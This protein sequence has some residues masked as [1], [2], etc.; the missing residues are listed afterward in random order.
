MKINSNEIPKINFRKEIN[1]LNGFEIKEI[2]DIY[3]KSYN[4]N[5][6]IYSFHKQQFNLIIFITKDNVKHFVD[7]ESYNLNSGDVLFITNNSVHAFDK[8]NSIQGQVILFTDEFLLNGVT[9]QEVKYINN[10]RRRVFKYPV[11]KK[12]LDNE[13]ILNLL[14]ILKEEYVNNKVTEELFY[15]NIL[16]SLII[17]LD[18]NIREKKENSFNSNWYSVMGLLDSSIENN[19]YRLRDSGSLAEGLGYGYKQ[20]NIICKTL[21]NKTVKKYIN[22][23]VI[24]EI[25]RKLITTDLSIKELCVYFNFDEDTNFVKFF[26]KETGTT[27]KKFKEKYLK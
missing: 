23:M 14:K 13:I 3:D 27:P 22:D 25:K 1:T 2:K 19:G 8:D 9:H 20:L 12:I 21:T 10:T 7:F 11:I 24:L 18:I 16:S 17:K 5:F 6:D 26:K 4:L 15:R